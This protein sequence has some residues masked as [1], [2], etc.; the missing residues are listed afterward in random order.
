MR[1]RLL[2]VLLISCAL[3]GCG[4]GSS[5]PQPLPLTI[6][7]ASLPNATLEIR[8]TQTIQATGGVGPYTWTVSSGALP[9]NLTLSSGTTN[10]VTI[11]GTPQAAAQAAAFTIEVTDSANQS[12]QQ[13][14]TVSIV[15]EPST[16]TFSPP[17][18]SFLPPQQVIGTVSPAQTETLTNTGTSEVV[19]SN[20]ALT[21]TNEA[22]FGQSNT[23]GS[24]LAA[25][26]SCTIN[27]TFTPS[28]LGA[29][30]ASITITDNTT[31]SPSSVSLSGVGL[32]SGPNATLS[33]TSLNFGSQAPGQP[34]PAQSI[35]L[36]NYG[37]MSLSSVD[38]A[39][40]TNF[41]ETSTC[42][43]TLSPGANC[44]IDVTFTPIQAGSQ[45]GTLSVTDNAADS[46]QICSLTGGSCVKEGNPCSRAS[47]SPYNC[48]AGLVCHNQGDN[49]PA[50]CC[51]ASHPFCGND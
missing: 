37:T 20:I 49:V 9:P 12:A 35:T 44:A 22:D 30:S 43:A 10:V 41:I 14:Y 29:R 3:S 25:G 19:I 5:Q 2:L 6:S 34:S 42:D 32:T 13:P 39:A 40:S 15:L 36:S 26:A 8:Y 21:G 31:G 24:T 17:S 27:V 23:C 33:A 48:C 50:V 4:G 7:T 51:P 18:L 28:Q 16:L 1:N 45:D 46:P 47:G 11:S 38:I